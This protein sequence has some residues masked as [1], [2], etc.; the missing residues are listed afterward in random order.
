MSAREALLAA[1]IAQLRGA[2]GLVGA[3][4]FD[5]APVRSALPYVQ[6]EEPLLSDWSTKSWAGREGG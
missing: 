6:V 1:T 2:A 3:S 5:T 4:V